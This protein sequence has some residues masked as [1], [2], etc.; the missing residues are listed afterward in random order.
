MAQVE[1]TMASASTGSTDGF[2]SR[3]QATGSAMGISDIRGNEK[4]KSA[5]MASHDGLPIDVGY[6]MYSREQTNV[7]S[8]VQSGSSSI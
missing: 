8:S 4:G 6:Q 5:L 2:T 1:G 3:A 7:S